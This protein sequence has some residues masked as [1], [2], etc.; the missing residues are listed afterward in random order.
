[1]FHFQK[2]PKLVNLRGK[3]KHKGWYK[4]Y[5]P[6]VKTDIAIH[7]SLTKTGNSAAFANYHV[8]T[9]GWPEVAYHFVILKDGTIE[10]N[11]DLGVL[12]YHVGDSNKF[13]VGICLV[14]DFRSEEP[15]DAQKLSLYLLVD[16]LKKDLPNYKRTRGHNEFPG[17]AWKECPV[18]DYKAVINKKPATSAPAKPVEVAVEPKKEAK[19]VNDNL[20]KP[21]SSACVNATSIVLN[22]LSNANVHGD[23]ALS[24]EWR[25]KLLN[26]E[27]TESDAI[28]LIYVALER[29]LFIGEKKEAE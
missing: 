25:K 6:S 15:T 9:L 20:Y 28:G 16:A 29:G 24:Q 7:H 10:W 3:T 5:D 19:V 4:V 14:G 23:K 2:L 27:L 13:S 18:F 17:Y 26:G 12:S 11:H 8:G 21:S 1:M 22:R